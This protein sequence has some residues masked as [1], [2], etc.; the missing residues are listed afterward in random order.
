[1]INYKTKTNKK[2]WQQQ[3]KQILPIKKQI[4]KQKQKNSKKTQIKINNDKKDKTKIK[5]KKYIKK[6]KNV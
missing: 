1:M 2:T 6:T 3:K 4:D 5:N